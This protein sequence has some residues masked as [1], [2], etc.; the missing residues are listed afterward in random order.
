MRLA[1]LLGAAALTTGLALTLPE[2]AEAR[3]RRCRDCGDGYYRDDHRRHS[4]RY[5]SQRDR[6]RYDRGRP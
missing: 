5:R 3:S 1:V 4:Y 6:Y 2:P